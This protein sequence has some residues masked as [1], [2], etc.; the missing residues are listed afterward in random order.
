MT[1]DE[2]RK[3]FLDILKS[4]PGVY[5]ICQNEAECSGLAHEYLTIQKIDEHWYFGATIVI[6]KYSNAKNVVNSISSH[7]RYELT[8][9]REK[10]GKLNIFIGGLTND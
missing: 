1:L 9:R 10:L 7:L 5:G 4:T 6:L 2:M 8:K 3:I